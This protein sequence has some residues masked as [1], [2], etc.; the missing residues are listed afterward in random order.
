MLSAVGV[1]VTITNTF[2]PQSSYSGEHMR[3]HPSSTHT[4]THTHLPHTHSRLLD[5][6]LLYLATVGVLSFKSFAINAMTDVT[7]DTPSPPP[8]QERVQGRDGRGGEIVSRNNKWNRVTM[9]TRLRP[10]T[11][12]CPEWVV[13]KISTGPNR[14]H[15]TT[16]LR[17]HKKQQDRKDPPQTPCQTS[18]GSAKVKTMT[19]LVRWFFFFP[20]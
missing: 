19:H 16:F 12:V 5:S 3:T 20:C 2:V 10:G 18:T 8:P 6:C 15:V 11:R 17:M 14:P 4:H 7:Q 9:M 1:H 13:T